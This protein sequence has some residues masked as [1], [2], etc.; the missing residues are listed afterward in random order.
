MMNQ[1]L[2]VNVYQQS[3]QHVDNML[4]PDVVLDFV[5]CY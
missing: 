5:V 3:H 2:I 4:L 1:N